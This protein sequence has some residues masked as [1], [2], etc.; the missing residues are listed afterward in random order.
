M[1][2]RCLA[3]LGFY[4]LLLNLPHEPHRSNY[5][6]PSLRWTQAMIEALRS[7][8]SSF[9][10]YFSKYTSN[11]FQKLP[12]MYDL[13][14]LLIGPLPFLPLHHGAWTHDFLHRAKKWRSRSETPSVTALKIDGTLAKTN[15]DLLP[16]PSKSFPKHRAPFSSPAVD[17]VIRALGFLHVM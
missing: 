10:L 16:R 14:S 13:L 1:S 17:F 2:D 9:V 4:Q 15:P 7:V 12:Y 11:I 6:N 8:Q 3:R 5:T